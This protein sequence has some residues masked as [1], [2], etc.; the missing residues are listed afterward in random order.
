MTSVP[1]LIRIFQMLFRLYCMKYDSPSVL[2]FTYR[3]FSL[4]LDILIM[5]WGIWYRLLWRYCSAIA[6][7][8]HKLNSDIGS[9]FYLSQIDIGSTHQH[10]MDSSKIM[11]YYLSISFYISNAFEVYS[12]AFS[13]QNLS[14]TSLASVPVALCTFLSERVTLMSRSAVVSHISV[15]LSLCDHQSV[16]GWFYC[17]IV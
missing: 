4:F 5:R 7:N 14:Y 16:K 2:I 9:L 17:I 1:K 15:V 11:T 6:N 8:F 3:R 12:L 13:L 10:L